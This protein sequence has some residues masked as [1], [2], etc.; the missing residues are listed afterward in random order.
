MFIVIGNYLPK[1]KQ[2]NTI[3][4]IIVLT[5]QDEENGMQL[6]ALVEGYGGI[7]YFMHALHI[8]FDKI[9]E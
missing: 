1:I 6:I 3:G 7:R 4:I 2:N 5:L 9:C 8:T